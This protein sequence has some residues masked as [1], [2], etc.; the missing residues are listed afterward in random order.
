MFETCFVVLLWLVLHISCA[1]PPASP[2]Y[3][4]AAT[5]C[6]ETHDG[7]SVRVHRC[8]GGNEK[9]GVKRMTLDPFLLFDAY[10]NDDVSQFRKGFP[11]HPHRGF[12]ELRYLTHGALHHQD[13]C[14]NSATTGAGGVQALFTG[15]GIVHEEMPVLPN[16]TGFC[17]NTE[18]CSET[19]RD[20]AAQQQPQL[21]GFQVWINVPNRKRLLPPRFQS[22]PSS[23]FPVI[24]GASVAS[25]AVITMIAGR[26]PGTP[27]SLEGPLSANFSTGLMFARVKT[28][29]SDGWLVVHDVETSQ[30]VLLYPI[31]G[32]LAV[33]DDDELPLEKDQL[34]FLGPGDQVRIKCLVSQV[35]GGCDFLFLT[36]PRV[37]EPVVVSGGFVAGD[38]RSLREAFE[39]LNSGRST[40]C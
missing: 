17:E 1:P 26:W 4:H 18:T 5:D 32:S 6:D 35:S 24:H 13:S 30:H 34:G 27:S 3:L 31:A 20:D 9:D 38:Q 11:A 8:L 36:A 33:G 10:R 12:L 23:Q 39:D 25:G 29:S 37:K 16:S 14:G 28:A 2:R 7:D 15:R 21:R 19:Q 22:F 40:N